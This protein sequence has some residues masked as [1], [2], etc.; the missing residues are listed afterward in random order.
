MFKQS[1]VDV[2]V[3]RV[4]VDE[5]IEK[6][7]IERKAPVLWRRSEGVVLPFSAVVKR[8]DSVLVGVQVVVDITFIVTKG[9]APREADGDNERKEP[10][11]LATIEKN[12]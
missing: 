9:S 5:A 8:M 4:A 6:E 11:H 1:A 2:I 7:S 10:P 12:D 3:G